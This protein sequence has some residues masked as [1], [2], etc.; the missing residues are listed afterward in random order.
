MEVTAAYPFRI[1]RNAD[2]EI[3]EDEASD[4]LEAT[5]EMVGQRHFGFVIRLEVDNRMPDQFLKILVEN[6]E[7][8]PYQVYTIDGPIGMADM[9]FVITRAK[10]LVVVWRGGFMPLA[11]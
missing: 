1:T 9:I 3:E 2:F 4:L 8:A 10:W 6:L 7:L 5:K 11:R